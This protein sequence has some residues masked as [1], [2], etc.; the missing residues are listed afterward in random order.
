MGFVLTD[1][2][3]ICG[4][5]Q[6]SKEDIVSLLEDS[7]LRQNLRDFSP[8]NPTPKYYPCQICGKCSKSFADFI[9]FW[10]QLHQGQILLSEQLKKEWNIDLERIPPLTS[11]FQAKYPSPKPFDDEDDEP[12]SKRRVIK[13]PRKFQDSEI[14]PLNP[15]TKENVSHIC[16]F[17]DKVFKK[18]NKLRH[19][20]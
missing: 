12:K 7:D 14:E 19:H 15:S 6:S 8:L 9:L 10:K 5:V 1:L 17:C 3:R 18:I 16:E 4:L 13:L 20:R 2:C 11:F